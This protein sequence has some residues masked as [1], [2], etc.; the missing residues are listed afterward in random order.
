MATPSPGSLLGQRS[1]ARPV[2]EA[3]LAALGGGISITDVT[4]RHVFGDAMAEGTRFAVEVDGETVA[5]VTGPA[6]AAQAASL[7][8]KHLSVKEGERKALAREVLHLY[9][10]I[11]LI[12]QLSEQLTALFDLETLGDTALQ[13]ARKLIQATDGVVLL[14]GTG[15]EAPLLVVA[16]FGDAGLAADSELVRTLSLRD[17]GDILNDVTGIPGVRSLLCAPLKA[18][19]HPI[20]VLMLTSQSPVTYAAADL[21]LL[22]TI[23]LQAAA[24][25]EN[26]MLCADMVRAARDREQLTSLQKELDVARS[27]QHSLL[28]RTA[29]PFPKRTDFEIHAA[30]TSANEVGGD[31]FDFFLVG[32]HQLGVVIG[33]VSGKGIPAALYMAVTRTQIKTTALGGSEPEQCLGAVNRF[34]VGEK[35]GRM[36]ATCFYG[37]LDTRN[38]EFRYA[39]AG[40]NPPYVRRT[41]GGIEALPLVGGLPLGV[42]DRPY[43][44]GRI[45]LA[46][47]DLLLLYTDGVTE[48]VDPQQELFSPA[49][50]QQCLESAPHLTSREIIAHIDQAVRTFTA[51]GPQS[52]DITMLALRRAA[53]L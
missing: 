44:S 20:G 48:A 2:L 6:G 14:R 19:Q 53:A 12:E 45:G 51:G 22:N 36:F 35:I 15:T 23:A 32:E 8:L 47:E 5:W 27:I 24:G 28:P 41:G 50:L 9:R 31:F 40:H 30:M 33:D 11:H 38:G 52:D 46:P 21:K 18:K 25:I 16:R 17:T 13:Q 49:R 10:E 39:N 7:L 4:G 42:M 29:N 1:D 34:L 37:V 26:A 43:A 3:L